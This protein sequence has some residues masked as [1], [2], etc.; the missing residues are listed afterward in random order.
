MMDGDAI[1][2]TTDLFNALGACVY[3]CVATKGD[4]RCSVVCSFF[5]GFWN[6]LR[7]KMFDFFLAKSFVP[8]TTNSGESTKITWS[9]NSYY[10]NL[11]FL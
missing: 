6:G 2:G 8:S 11:S 10:Q 1:C 4:Y 5:R 7:N 9:W 3:V